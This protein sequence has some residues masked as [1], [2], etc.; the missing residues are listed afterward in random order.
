MDAN[1]EAVLPAAETPTL[2]T[3]VHDVGGSA[4]DFCSRSAASSIAAYT[5]ETSPGVRLRLQ[6]MPAWSACHSQHLHSHLE[7]SQGNAML[8]AGSVASTMQSAPVARAYRPGSGSHPGASNAAVLK[9]QDAKR[10]L[11]ADR[12]QKS[13]RQP[14]Q[15]SYLRAMKKQLQEKERRRLDA[16][17]TERFVQPLCLKKLRRIAGSRK[18]RHPTAELNA[19]KVAAGISSEPESQRAQ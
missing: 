6:E 11:D 13:D 16:S 9:P 3:P 19:A 1:K 10:R 4:A 14:K 15:Q 8:P 12:G 7:H 17:Q 18:C 2:G 5:T